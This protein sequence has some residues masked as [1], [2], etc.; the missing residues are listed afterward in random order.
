[1]S[2]EQRRQR[3]K[4]EVEQ[5]QKQR[6]RNKEIE[7]KRSQADEIVPD[8]EDVNGPPWNTA[9]LHYLQSLERRMDRIEEKLGIDQS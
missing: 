1:M 2:K 9:V 6:Q 4:E 7:Q 3:A 5:R 8:P